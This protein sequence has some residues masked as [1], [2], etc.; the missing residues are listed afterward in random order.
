VA[1]NERP[2]S[3]RRARKRAKYRS[4]KLGPDPVGPDPVGPDP[5][6]GAGI[7]LLGIF[8]MGLTGATGHHHLFNASTGVAV[9]GALLFVLFVTITSYRQDR[10]G[11]RG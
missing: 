7:A 4:D 8:A 9:L 3:A 11:K 2:R 1:P 10:A 5:A 6:L